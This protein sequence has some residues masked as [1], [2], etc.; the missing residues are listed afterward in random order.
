MTLKTPAIA[1]E[2]AVIDEGADV[3]RGTAIGHFSYVA[4]AARIGEQCT[5]TQ[6]VHVAAGVLVGNRVYL[7]N[8]V[9]L[10]SGV[11]LED[12]VVCGPGVV[13]AP[14]ESLRGISDPA[15][16]WR[17]T[18]VGRG[19]L[20]GA[21]ATIRSGVSIG[22][23]AM[24]DAGALVDTDVPAHAFVS[25]MPARRH[26]WVSRSGERLELPASGEAEAVC[27]RGGERYR[28]QGERLHRLADA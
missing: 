16:G 24:V 13:F 8:H 18:H 1:H 4:S 21:N 27:R 7:D 17:Q 11:V 9:S 19:A 25:G 3:G 10:C 20:L 6:G 14:A 5:L 12:E 23:F 26:G 15:G 22:E 28:L 2:S